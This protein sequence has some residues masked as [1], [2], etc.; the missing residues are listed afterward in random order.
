MSRQV[1]PLSG[2]LVNAKDAAMLQPGELSDAQNCLFLPGGQALNRA[3]GRV[4]FGTVSATAVDVV[5][6]RNT[7]FDNGDHYLVAHATASY[8]TA[9]VG[10][11]GTFATLATGIG[12][13][14]QLE[15]VQYRNQWFLFNGT[16]A[17]STGVTIGSNRVIY[18]SATA[19]GTPPTLRQHGMIAVAAGPAAVLTA[20]TFSQ[21]VTGYYDYWT[22]ELAKISADGIQTQLESTFV[23]TPTTVFVTSTGQAPLISMPTVQNAITTH[24]RIYR[25]P[26][27]A[28]ATDKK[29]PTGFMVLEN[30]TAQAT[31]IDQSTTTDTGYILP[32]NENGVGDGAT[33][34]AAWSNAA[35][36]SADNGVYAS[37]QPFSFG[38][39]TNTVLQGVYG[40]NFGGFTGSVGGIEVQIKGYTNGAPY[41]VNVTI[42][43]A[44][45]SNGG[46][47]DTGASWGQQII[48][49]T[50]NTATRSTTITATASGSPQ[51]VSLGG[52]T[53]RWMP[54]DAQRPF[55]SSDFGT[56]FMAV[57]NV[58]KFAQI[59]I[60]F[61]KV[62]VYYNASID[63][64]IQF[65][66]VVYTFGDITS[67]V[68]KRGTP[69]S[70]STG[71][72]Y[73]G[74]LVVNDVDSPRLVR[75]SFPDEPESFPSTYFIPFDAEE[76]GRV[77][78]IKVVNNRCLVGLDRSLWRLNYLPNERDAQFDRGKAK[79]PIS[80]SYGVVNPMCA[81]T[82]SIERQGS[83]TG[84]IWGFAPQLLAWV[85]QQGIHQTD[86]YSFETLTNDIDWRGKI[87]PLGAS[88]PIALVNDW[89]RQQ[90][91]F[92]FQNANAGNETYLCLP[93]CYNV[94]HLVQGKPKA[95]GIIHMRNWS[96]AA[97]GFADLKSAW[98]VPRSN[99]TCDVVLGYGGSVTA[100]G[101]GK[102]YRETGTSIPA[103][104]D[105]MGYV[106][107]RLYLAGQ[108]S[109][110]TL[111]EV[112]GY[113]GSYS[114]SPVVTYT[115]NS[116]KTNDSGP[117]TRGSRAITLAG[118]KLH[119]AGLMRT[120]G[121]GIQ[122]SAVVSAS[123]YAQE[124]LV[125]DGTGWGP[126][127][128][129]R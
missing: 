93:F 112:Y 37:A 120:N 20:G 98:R 90:L 42:G 52:P 67:Q 124:H 73:E 26:L 25:S 114:G 91:L 129:G 108:S 5:G 123:A 58:S 49:L 7:Q 12:A 39:I 56:D 31:A 105:T 99:G 30:A 111:D 92:F 54:P 43:R 115:V 87:L 11:T 18:L 116:T 110:W 127:D 74:S 78:L 84:S 33:V 44:R 55:N 47:S 75:Y 79:E 89:E 27:K 128:S 41:P 63:S 103:Q 1:E 64:T 109:E 66:T 16:S 70:S 121:E 32:A 15:A 6:L 117:I 102:V 17:S 36:L 97:S 13:G 118:Q 82:Y 68:G 126:E 29:F 40:F 46:W 125:L 100:A 35:T 34:F 57:L 72:I 19:A 119:K 106:T 61:V 10:D 51:T 107:R 85:S 76:G 83:L 81:C 24:W 3:R 122:V 62:R 48:D 113:V 21:S 53:D 8:L 60:D 22:T 50:Y 94:Q 96:A 71:D 9:V 59:N 69:P 14:A 45:K 104:D 38:S 88:T 80:R 86:G 2:P 23:G 77:R 28:S 95:G 65:P 101:A 4:S